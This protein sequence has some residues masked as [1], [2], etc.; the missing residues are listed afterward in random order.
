[1][2]NKAQNLYIAVRPVRTLTFIFTVVGPSTLNKTQNLYITVLSAR[3]LTL[4]FTVLRRFS[5]HTY[6]KEHFTKGPF[7]TYVRSPA[8]DIDIQHWMRSK[9]AESVIHIAAFSPLN[10]HTT[11]VS[12][13]Y[14]TDDTY[15]NCNVN[16]NSDPNV[17]GLPTLFQR[18]QSYTCVSQCPRWVLTWHDYHDVIVGKTTICY[19]TFISALP[20]SQTKWWMHKQLSS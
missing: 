13:P 8:F 2:L 1:M 12:T 16:D 11:S 3:L 14:F 18:H 9:T 6:K 5:T 19:S 10:Y 17:A 15:A 4:I 7:G 20:P